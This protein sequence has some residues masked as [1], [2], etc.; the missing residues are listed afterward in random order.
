M[1]KPIGALTNTIIF[2]ERQWKTGAVVLSCLILLTVVWGFYLLE[3]PS[4]EM[5]T[6]DY[7]IAG[8]A[9]MQVASDATAT[10]SAVMPAMVVITGTGANANLRASGVI[11]SADGLVITSAEA[12]AGLSQLQVWVRTAKGLQPYAAKTV[13][14]LSDLGLVMMQMTSERRFLYL[15]SASSVTPQHGSMVTAIGVGANGQPIIKTGSLMVGNGVMGFGKNPQWLQTDAIYS[16]EQNG[17][18][19]IDSSGHLLGINLLMRDAKGGIQGYAVPASVLPGGFLTDKRARQLVTQT[20][21]AQP[22]AVLAAVWN[23]AEHSR[24][25]RIGGFTLPM[26][27]QLALLSFIAGIMS[28]MMTMGGGII[29]VTGMMLFFGYSMYLVRPVAYIT[30]S[31]VFVASALRNRKSGFLSH[32]YI[33]PL[34]PWVVAG[35]LLGFFMGN[36][37]GDALVAHI[38]GGVALIL[39]ARAIFEIFFQVD[40][41]PVVISSPQEEEQDI[42]DLLVTKPAPPIDRHKTRPTFLQ[43]ILLGGSLGLI[44]G[45]LGISGGV[46]GVPLQ[47]YVGGLSLRNA[48]ANSS[49][50]VFFASITGVFITFIHGASTGRLDWQTPV[51]IAAIMAPSAHIGGLFG[52]KLLKVVPVLVLNWVYAA[53]MLIIAVRM[54]YYN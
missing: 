7:A 39:G 25:G 17:G 34:L 4:V 45:M 1:N 54:I 24:E 43:Q 50:L 32:F 22:K 3:N 15:P 26:M 30:N 40:D 12:F 21:I 37:A 16:W 42:L 53:L 49:V 52:A 44:S 33:V 46:V 47:R 41:K 31:I 5:E 20:V 10:W 27:L 38:I 36:L 8:P 23:D 6:A 18:A 13:T 11:V 48:I 14:A 35:V 29:Q 19:L 9:F 2:C 28:G 51:A